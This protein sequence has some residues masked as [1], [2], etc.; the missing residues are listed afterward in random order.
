MANHQYSSKIFNEHKGDYAA[1]PL[2]LG[3]DRGLMDTLH[4][5]HPQIDKLIDRL[6]ALNWGV[7]DFPFKSCRLDFQRC[8]K[9]SYDVMMYNIAWQW[10]TDTAATGFFPIMA[11]FIS[12]SSLTY[13]YAKICDNEVLHGRTYAEMV[14][15]S[16][17]DPNAALRDILD[18]KQAIERLRPIIDVFAEGYEVSHNYALGK[19]DNNQETYNT[20]FKLIV[21]NYVMEKFQFPSSFAGTFAQAETGEFNPIGMAVQRICQDELEIHAVLGEMILDIEIATDRGRR[22]LSQLW[23]WIEHTIKLIVDTELRW[24]DFLLSE[25]RSLEKATAYQLKQTAL[26]FAGAVYQFFRIRCPYETPNK[27]PLP[28]LKNWMKVSQVR[29]APQESRDG[30]YFVGEIIDDLGDE[31]LVV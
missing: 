7:N 26:Y 25:G 20:V 23:S 6:K 19:L 21:V 8:S 29:R 16:F 13:A 15:Q 22:A 18:R 4:V 3:E 10:E 11:P 14:R 28:Y 9:S 1:T 12:S 31:I 24:I 5:P 27:I 17:D 2:F 30:M